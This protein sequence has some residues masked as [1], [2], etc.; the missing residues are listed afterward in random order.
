MLSRSSLAYA[1]ESGRSA[2]APT[3]ASHK[4]FRS[5]Q[6]PH[7]SRVIRAGDAHVLP[8]TVSLSSVAAGVMAS[9][10]SRPVEASYA[11]DWV[12]RSIRWRGE[13]A[14]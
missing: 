13:P 10:K 7:R 6:L 14:I 1:R 4:P 3:L 11:G 9:A 8:R 5:R 12:T 2:N